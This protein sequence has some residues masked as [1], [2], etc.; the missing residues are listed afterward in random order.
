[1]RK[2]DRSLLQDGSQNTA[3]APWVDFTIGSKCDVSPWSLVIFNAVY[4][5]MA[6]AINGRLM[7]LA[8][9]LDMGGVWNELLAVQCEQQVLEDAAAEE[10]TQELLASAQSHCFRSGMGNS[11]RIYQ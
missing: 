6:F 1:M 10:I 11:I 8:L 3:L 5:V 9:V 7:V 4:N 2:P